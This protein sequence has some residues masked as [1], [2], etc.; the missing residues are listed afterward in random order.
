MHTEQFR[1]RHERLRELA[2]KFG[3][4]A[5]VVS[6]KLVYHCPPGKSW[7]ACNAECIHLADLVYENNRN[8]GAIVLAYVREGA[9]PQAYDFARARPEGLLLLRTEWMPNPIPWSV[10]DAIRCQIPEGLESMPRLIA[11]AW[12]KDNDGYC[13]DDYVELG[14][15]F[16]TSCHPTDSGQWEGPWQEGTPRESYSTVEAAMAAHDESL[17]AR[18]WILTDVVSPIAL[19]KVWD[20][21]TRSWVAKQGDPE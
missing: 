4:S 7:M 10:L 19:G 12:R 16:A 5:E 18:G 1:R 9:A 20:D 8:D 17:R 11:Y 21:A 2:T 6:D 13:R 3:G 15:A 14:V